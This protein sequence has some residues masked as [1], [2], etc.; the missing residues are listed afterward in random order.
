M[1][2]DVYHNF[3][4]KFKKK[5]SLLCDMN[6]TAW[7]YAFKVARCT[8]NTV[9]HARDCYVTLPAQIASLPTTPRLI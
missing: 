8:A 4:D 1:L 5:F 2:S 7:L 9:V 3:E 6:F